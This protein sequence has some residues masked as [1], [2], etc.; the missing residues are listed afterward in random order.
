MTG[1]QLQ[2]IRLRCRLTIIDLAAFLGVTKGAVSRWESDERKIP[3]PVERLMLL[4]DESDGKLF[5]ENPW[6]RG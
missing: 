5:S 2:T 3:G 6:N 1:Q 4:L